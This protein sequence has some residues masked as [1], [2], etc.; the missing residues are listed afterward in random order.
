MFK[1]HIRRIEF[2]ALKLGNGVKYSVEAK[3][4]RRLS[5]QVAVN[6]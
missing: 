5:G 6:D 1:L 2:N 3:S 4:A